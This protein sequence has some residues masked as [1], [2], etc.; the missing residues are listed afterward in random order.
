MEVV[1]DADPDFIRDADAIV[2]NVVYGLLGRFAVGEIEITQILPSLDRT[3]QYLT[4]SYEA[5][6]TEPHTKNCPRS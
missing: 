4:T 3:V 2:T 1:A 6:P 5:G